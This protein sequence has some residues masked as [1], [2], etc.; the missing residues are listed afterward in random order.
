MRFVFFQSTFWKTYLFSNVLENPAPSIQE[1][2]KMVR[3]SMV[4]NT[5]MRTG[6][7]CNKITP[8]FKF[9]AKIEM[10]FSKILAN[11]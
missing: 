4:F 8:E 11:G 6:Y 2:M 7:S 10:A 5:R 3:V 1:W 9:P